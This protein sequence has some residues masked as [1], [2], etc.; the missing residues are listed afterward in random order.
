MTTITPGYIKGLFFHLVRAVGGVE[1]AGAYL[2]ISHQRVSQL[3]NTQSADMP[4][5]M[6]VAT[7]EAAVGQDLVTGALSR[8]VTGES[9]KGNL[10]TESCEAVEAA[11]NVLHLSR[12]GASPRELHKAA[13]TLHRESEDILDTIAAKTGD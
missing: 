1:A 7:L 3:Q 11:T 2:G 12:T 9:G 4:T 6:H 5:I 8:A 10:L 13:T